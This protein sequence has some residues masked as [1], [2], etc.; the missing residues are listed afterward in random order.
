VRRPA[1]ATRAHVH[2]V[3]VDGP[4]RASSPELMPRLFAPAREQS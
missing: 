4:T 3:I 1:A 2:L